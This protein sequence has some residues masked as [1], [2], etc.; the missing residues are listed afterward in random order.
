[1]A[2]VPKHIL[3]IED[4]LVY[5][6]Q[7]KDLLLFQGYHVAEAGN[8]AEAI[9]ILTDHKPHLILMDISLPDTDGLTLV[10]QFRA[11]LTLADLPIVALTAYVSRGTHKQL[12]QAGFTS[13]ISK[14]ADIQ[15]LLKQIHKLLQP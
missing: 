6:Q 1:M 7:T 14:P 4:D 9:A 12:K 13:Y 11:D 8:A 3:L 15:N 5:R 2:S 10:K